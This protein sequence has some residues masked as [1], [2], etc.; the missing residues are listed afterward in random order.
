MEYYL[1][2][3]FLSFSFG[4]ATLLAIET[5]LGILEDPT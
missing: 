4:L 3:L 5:V 1:T 2:V